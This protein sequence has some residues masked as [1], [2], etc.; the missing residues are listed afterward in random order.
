MYLSLAIEY[1]DAISNKKVPTALSAMQVAIEEE[2]A[3]A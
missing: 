2:T 3:S 1:C